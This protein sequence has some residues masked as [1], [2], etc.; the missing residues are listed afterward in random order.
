MATDCFS[1]VH[2]FHLIEHDDEEGKTF[3]TQLHLSSLENYD[4]FMKDYDDDF[5]KKATDKWGDLFISFRTIL[6][7][8]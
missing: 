6:K 8:I 2:F 4:K 1:D 7:K 5:R 3:V